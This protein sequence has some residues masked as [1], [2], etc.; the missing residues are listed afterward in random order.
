LV[1]GR[2]VTSNDIGASHEPDSPI[3]IGS[4][5][6][7]IALATAGGADRVETQP[8]LPLAATVAAVPGAVTAARYLF[9]DMPV[10]EKGWC[11]YCIVD[12][13]AHIA[14]FGFTLWESKKAIDRLGRDESSSP[15]DAAEVVP[16]QSQ[17]ERQ[18]TS[19]ANCPCGARAGM[20]AVRFAG[21]DRSFY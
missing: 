7:S 15:R 9:H 14:V 8:L 16:R 5:A 20:I 2:G 3:S 10:T 1:R 21:S 4:H 19:L 11:P 13:L 6:A 12:A 17:Y 18:S